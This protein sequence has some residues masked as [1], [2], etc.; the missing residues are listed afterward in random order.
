MQKTMLIV[1]SVD[2]AEDDDNGNG[3]SECQ[4]CFLIIL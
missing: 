1:L 2:A 4:T 3:C